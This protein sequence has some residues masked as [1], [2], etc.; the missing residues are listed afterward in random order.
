MRNL[1]LVS[2]I[3]P[4]HNSEKFIEEA[5][6][7]VLSQTY[8]NWELLL[9]DDGSADGSSAIAMNYSERHKLKVCYFEHS[10]HQNRGASTS[11]NLGI[12]KSTGQYISFLDA[13]DV[14]FNNTME[15]QVQI[16]E[17]NQEAAVVCG[18][19]LYWY[20]WTGKLED[21]KRDYVQT[22]GVNPGTLLA[23]PLMR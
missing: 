6:E 14:W 5:I 20:S 18:S 7:S 2:V 11:R 22:L 13:D 16:L 4:F 12:R 1:P 9:I 8:S 23:P 17:D 3:M 19:T 10:D 15:Q 21:I